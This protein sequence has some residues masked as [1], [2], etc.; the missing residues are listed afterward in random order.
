MLTS[1]HAYLTFRVTRGRR[2]ARWSVAGG[3]LPDAPG[4]LFGLV[5]S[6]R[7]LRGPRLIERLYQ[8]QPYRATHELAHSLPLALA[9]LAAGPAGSRRRAVALGW[10]GHLVVDAVTHHTD[11]WP[12][13]FPLSRRTWAAPVSYWEP[14][15]HAAAY[16]AAE[17]VVLALTARPTSVRAALAAAATAA[18]ARTWP[19][20]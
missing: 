16:R 8:E 3:V 18:S 4:W 5:L 2:H 13:L 9:L 10:L 7:G 11:A 17:I 1:T 20:R 19:P 6:A 14:G 15:H 12:L